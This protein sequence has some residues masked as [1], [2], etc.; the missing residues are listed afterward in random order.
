MLK[1]L[2][3]GYATIDLIGGK[4]HLGGAA[5][6]MSVNA[7]FLGVK[8]SLLTVLAKDKHGDFYIKNLKKAR[9]DF[10]L[11]YL[12]AT[13]LP[14][15]VINRA[16]DFGSK[17]DW[18]DNGANK[19]LK[20]IKV[21]KK[22]LSRFDAVF[23]A[24]CNPVLAETVARNKPDN[25]FYIPGPQS[26]LQKNYIK[27][28]VLKRAR[29]V[30]GN[31][32]EA[33]FIFEKQPFKLGVKTVVITRGKNGGTVFLNTSERIDFNASG[34]DKVIDSTGAGDNFALGFGIRILDGKSIQYAI[35]YGKKLAARVIEREGGLLSAGV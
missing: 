21:T 32:E 15:C 1:I 22:D 19:Y 13:N 9:V 17:R 14:T 29:I 2:F 27:E 35:E 10:S 23:L 7:S 33:P 3:A 4:F 31:E 34:T 8:S 16:H 25:L 26:V 6:V 18:S 20:Q 11:S 28:E 12:D 24:N 30:F 5:G